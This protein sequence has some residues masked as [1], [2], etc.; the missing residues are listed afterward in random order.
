MLSELQNTFD[1]P[2]HVATNANPAGYATPADMK[3]MLDAEFLLNKK[4]ARQIYAQEMLE[5]VK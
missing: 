1:R 5:R 4:L 3:E 2:A